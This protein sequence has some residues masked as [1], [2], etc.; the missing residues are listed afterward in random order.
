MGLSLEML[1]PLSKE[2]QNRKKTDSG[3]IMDSER[4]SHNL[5]KSNGFTLHYGMSKYSCLWGSAV[6]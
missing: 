1:L 5:Q 2:N 4:Q 3:A 6:R